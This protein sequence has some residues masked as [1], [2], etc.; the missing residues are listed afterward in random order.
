M[1]L[2]VAAIPGTVLSVTVAPKKNGDGPFTIA[3][4]DPLERCR[5]DAPSPLTHNQATTDHRVKICQA[6]PYRRRDH[7]L[8]RL[9]S[10]PSSVFE[11]ESGGRS[12]T[13]DLE[14]SELIHAV[15]SDYDEIVEVALRAAADSGEFRVL[16]SHRAAA[17]PGL[18]SQFLERVGA[19]VRIRSDASLLSADAVVEGML[20]HSG[21]IHSPGEAIPLITSLGAQM[22]TPVVSE[23]LPGEPPPQGWPFSRPAITVARERG[24]SATTV[25][26]HVQVDGEAH[27]ITERPIRVG[28]SPPTTDAH[29]RLVGAT[30]G[31]SRLHCTLVREGAH[32]IVEDHSRHGSF[33]GEMRIKD[34]AELVVGDRLRLGTPGIELQ[35]IRV[36]EDDGA[37]QD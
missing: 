22:A 21:A 12:H 25:P 16:F 9:E 10:D 29:I 26:S 4:S 11:I 6:A 20:A 23:T 18:R 7:W 3:I 1:V 28:T 31:I 15:A 33:L 37:A 14:R 32:V 35:M 8:D 24:P 5:T 13:A 27:P 17:L 19:R 34:R 36:V 2:K 30:A